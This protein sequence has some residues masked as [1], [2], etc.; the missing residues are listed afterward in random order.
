MGKYLNYHLSTQSPAAKEPRSAAGNPSDPS[1]TK[2]PTEKGLEKPRDENS[3][4]EP[5]DGN[6]NKS[7]IVEGAAMIRFVAVVGELMNVY[8][9]FSC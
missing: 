7:G 2:T 8:I 9:Q 6:Q 1:T 5:G 4:S 3:S